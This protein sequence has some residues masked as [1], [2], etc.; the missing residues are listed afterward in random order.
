MTLMIEQQFTPI[1]QQLKLLTPSQ[2]QRLHQNLELT[3]ISP[4]EVLTVKAPLHECPHCKSSQLKPWGSSHGL[5]RYRCASCCKTCNP[6][7]KTPLTRLRKRDK[8]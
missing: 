4:E 3:E 5:P 7:T 1:I 6:L 8:H 2:R